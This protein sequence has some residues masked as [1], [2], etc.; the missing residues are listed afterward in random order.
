MPFQSQEMK[1]LYAELGIEPNASSDDVRRAYR[2][3]ALETHPDKLDPG[4]NDKEKEEAERQF[5]R[6]HEAFE[7]LT[8]PVKRKAYDSRMNARTDPSLLSE[9]AKRRIREREEWARRQREESEKRMA[10]F[11][12]ELEREK[13]EKQEALE[14]MA[15]EAAMV[16]EM[17]QDMYQL[18]P[19]FAARRQAMLQRR[20]ERERAKATKLHKHPMQRPIHS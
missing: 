5:H 8:D 16:S 11:K 2:K 12:A 19:E 3:R 15:K 17:V 1:N 6:V 10:A 4:A 20:A 14:K 7:V 13:R 9:E 18:N